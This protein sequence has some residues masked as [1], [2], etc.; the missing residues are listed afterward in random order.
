MADLNDE[1]NAATASLS[2][3]SSEFDRYSR[4]TAGAA[5]SS[6]SLT[7]AQRAQ[8]AASRSASD[9]L[10]SLQKASGSLGSS[11][12]E[13]R[14]GMAAFSTAT[15]ATA[16]ATSNFLEAL[17]KGIGAFAGN[18]LFA[19][20]LAG[21]SN[22]GAAGIK[23]AATLYDLTSDMA[24][25]QYDAYSKLS[26]TGAIASEGMTGVGDAA[27]KLGLNILKMDE[28]IGLVNTNSKELALFGKSAFDGRRRFENLGQAL[29]KDRESFFALGMTQEQVNES[30][31]GF[32]RLQNLAGKSQK[33]SSEEL[34]ASTRKYLYEQDALA[35]LL[36]MSRKE[37]Q[38]AREAALSEQRFGA[39]IAAMRASGDAQQIAAAEQLQQQNLVLAS[40]S[41]ELAQGFRDLTTGM[42]TTEAAQKANM[43]TQGKIL[44]DIQ[45][46]SSGMKTGGEGAYSSLQA[47][48][49]TSAKF[50]MAYQMGT[51]ENFLVKFAETQKAREFLEK[52]F[53]TEMKAILKARSE[54]IAE[55][56]KEKKEGGDPRLIQYAALL[57]DQQQI[58]VALQ[59]LVNKGIKIEFT[60]GK[61]INL[62]ATTTVKLQQGITDSIIDLLQNND[63]FKLDVRKAGT[64]K[65]VS[66]E[67]RMA[68]QTVRAAGTKTDQEISAKQVETAQQ[69]MN[70]LGP[71]NG[72]NSYEFDKAK[73]EFDEATI[74]HAEYIK[75]NIK[76]QGQ[77]RETKKE[78]E[79]ARL[80]LKSEVEP[81]PEPPKAEPAADVSAEENEE[82]NKQIQAQ[83]QERERA[84]RKPAAPKND[85]GTVPEL[86]VGGNV[87][88]EDLLQEHKDAINRLIENRGLAPVMGQEPGSMQGKE[89]WDKQL[90]KDPEI[91]KKLFDLINEQV[92]LDREQG[93]SDLEQKKKVSEPVAPNNS[94]VNDT[95]P[96]TVEQ[97][98]ANTKN[99]PTVSDLIINS[100]VATLNSKGMNVT[101]DNSA[102]VARMLTETV[103]AAKTDV[104]KT[105]QSTARTSFENS[106]SDVKTAL[107]N[108]KDTNEMLLSAI[109]ELIRVQKNG[110][111]VNEKILAGQA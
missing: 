106:L 36:G 89:S 79:A 57:K 18:K 96:L 93:K 99:M 50:N 58:M 43:S 41:P 59:S 48:A 100:D 61:E 51:G 92:K 38:S 47:L 73:K 110:V 87:Q 17:T 30:M 35:K 7:A 103:I 107:F 85:L 49:T 98:A 21:I 104:G 105:D 75:A 97:V 10:Y 56:G 70:K 33:M 29:E 80:A 2:R 26:D 55:D 71:A 81:T 72:K 37:Q 12:Y 28:Y 94:R 14:R 11:L 83:K 111:S 13:G 19:G 31:I 15:T 39:K 8:A 64:E 82:I 84:S 78:L 65:T 54:L 74:K 108:Q 44:T 69:K 90:K 40:V 24:D 5:D 9:S 76:A 4:L 32:I 88:Y 67:D 3:L 53:N 46:V 77:L 63:Y 60:N 42:M 34:T 109:Q 22:M 68:T 102:D 1:V 86:K 23:V 62:S 66:L 52:D 25:R 27:E 45:E 16:V 91:Q 101:L 20:F 6:N 95:A